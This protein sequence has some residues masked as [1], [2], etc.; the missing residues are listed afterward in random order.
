[1]FS[2]TE[3]FE[4]FQEQYMVS[5]ERPSSTGPEWSR[6]SLIARSRRAPKLCPRF[7]H[8]GRPTVG[9]WPGGGQNWSPEVRLDAGNGEPFGPES[10]AQLA[11]TVLVGAFGRVAK[12]NL[13]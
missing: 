1:M 11:I 9:N 6:P 7:L 8:R 3:N 4:Y 13:R 12:A 10:C 2:N 5:A